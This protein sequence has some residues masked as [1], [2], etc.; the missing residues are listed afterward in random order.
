MDF[1][2]L[3]VQRRAIRDFTSQP[4]S[5]DDIRAIVKDA[6]QAPSWS[7][8]QPWHVT[9]ATG[10]ALDQ[11]KTQHAERVQAHVRG[12]SE[13]VPTH[14][15]E[16]SGQPRANMAAFGEDWH[17]FADDPVNML[18]AQGVLFHAPALLYLTVAKSSSTW[19]YYDLGGFGQL[20]MLA[21]TNRGIDSMP[22]YE[23][24]K[25][26]DIVRNVLPIADDQ[27][28]AMGIALGYRSNA[29]INGMHA[30]RPELDSIL[31]IKD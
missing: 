13:L 29:P 31:T 28:L 5:H 6:Q 18:D 21:A 17:Q 16:W 14:R 9:V 24:V 23:I 8:S 26:P 2:D 19:S 1:N 25:Y 10:A 4:V 15:N 3:L 7:D 11:I 22:A 20:L 12:H 30:Y 27:L